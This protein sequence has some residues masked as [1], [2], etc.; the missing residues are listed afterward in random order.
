[1]I[2]GL[3]G[4][5]PTSDGWIALVGLI[6]RAREAF[7]ETIDRTDLAFETDRAALF[8]SVGEAMSTRTTDEWRTTL[9]ELGIRHAPVRDR[10][11]VVADPQVWANDY[12]VAP[13]GPDGPSIVGSP[14]TFSA[15]TTSH[16]VEVPTLGQHTDDVLSEL[17]YTSDEIVALRAEGAV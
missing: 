1:M 17:G 12:L 2:P 4:I 3:Y 14:I 10:V 8:A 11:A 5:F 7:L 15:S 6:G 9:T 13:L 16:V